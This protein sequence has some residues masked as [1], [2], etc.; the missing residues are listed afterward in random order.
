MTIKPIPLPFGTKVKVTNLKNDKSVVV[1]ITDRG[2]FTKGREIDITKKAFSDLTQNKAQGL[3]N[4][5]I[6]RITN[7]DI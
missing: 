4:V 6:E 2:P 1:T 5:K 3:L 7:D